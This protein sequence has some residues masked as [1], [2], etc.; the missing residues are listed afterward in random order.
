LLFHEGPY[1]TGKV[2]LTKSL[3]KTLWR[4][5]EQSGFKFYCVG[6]NRERLLSS[7]AKLGS[8]RFWFHVSVATAFMTALSWKWL[9]WKGGVAWFIPMAIL[10]EVLY[11]V[12][13]RAALVCPDCQF[14]PILFLVDRKKAVRQVE[15]AWRQRFETKG[16]PFP[17]RKFSR[18]SSH[19]KATSAS[20]S[21]TA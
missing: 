7:P 3:S 12:R 1:Y 15:A 5:I 16:L 9:A 2:G 11:R 4:Q 13:M 10:F 14:D 6:C 18:Y 17:D 21:K 20:K 19:S 8:A